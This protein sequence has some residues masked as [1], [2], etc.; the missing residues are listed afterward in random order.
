MTD[1]FA[2]EGN[3]ELGSSPNPDAPTPSPA[4]HERA[5]APVQDTEQPDGQASQANPWDS[6]QSH[7]PSPEARVESPTPD[8][9]VTAAPSGVDASTAQTPRS[10]AE[11]TAPVPHGAPTV[12]PPGAPP[13]T[14][15]APQPGAGTPSGAQWGAQPGMA[16]GETAFGQASI[17]PGTGLPGPGGH[18]AGGHVSGG[19]VPGGHVPPGQASY[20]VGRPVANG[21][22]QTM[23]GMPA[24]GAYPMG[25]G[26]APSGQMPAG[27]MPPG[28]MPTG[29]LPPG[30]V[31]PG[32]MPPGGYGGAQPPGHAKS[33]S[34][35]PWIIIGIVLF[36]GLVVAAAGGFFVLRALNADPEPLIDMSEDT[37]A[38]YS[39]YESFDE[40]TIEP[41]VPSEGGSEG[42]ALPT[43]PAE[44][45]APAPGQGDLPFTVPDGATI[46]GDVYH[47]FNSPTGITAIAPMDIAVNET[48]E[49]KV[50]PAQ[51]V[52]VKVNLKQGQKVTIAV[53]GELFGDYRF[54]ITSP[55]NELVAFGDDSPDSDTNEEALDPKI[56]FEPKADGVYTILVNNSFSIAESA[57]KISVHE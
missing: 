14:Q 35:L 52:P 16:P 49:G 23:P 8:P 5:T 19:H 24:H 40:E 10:G 33:S 15:P 13:A 11:P 30:S 55:T 28:A 34:A 7:A 46:Q 54:W 20:G 32:Q 17:S 43:S 31:P 38:E 9:A 44:P 4:E 12:P 2:S 41:F 3:A 42:A 25:A 57:F 56:Q 37:T 26:P 22:Q 1:P 45:P 48:K 36:L 29:A 51:M 6:T 53:K 18:V 39:E 47:D 27:A 21:G 50:G